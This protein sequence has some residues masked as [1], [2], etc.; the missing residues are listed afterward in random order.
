MAA[1]PPIDYQQLAQ[2]LLAN[3]AAAGGAAGAVAGGGAAPAAAT[4]HYSGGHMDIERI[5]S[6]MKKF[7][8]ENC[9]DT[10][11]TVLQ[12][13]R[14]FLDHVPNVFKDQVVLYETRDDMER[15]APDAVDTNAFSNMVTR[16][17]KEYN[18][19]NPGW[20][21]GGG[22]IRMGR[23]EH[24]PEPIVP[25]GLTARR[26]HGTKTGP[27]NGHGP[28]GN[29]ESCRGM[30]H[31]MAKSAFWQA[32]EQFPQLPEFEDFYEAANA[33]TPPEPVANRRS[34]RT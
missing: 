32:H 8:S 10:N 2:T 25:C 4:A 12:N 14:T 16:L 27:D 11:A 18:E 21:A 31:N 23:F 6:S 22:D 26:H 1:L 17:Q 7:L 3:V 29:Q 33:V 19:R 34:A 13:I 30:Y 24:L 5:E 28:P 9:V 15:I 20:Q